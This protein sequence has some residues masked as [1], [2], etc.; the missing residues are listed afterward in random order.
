ME[1]FRVLRTS[2]ALSLE[3]LVSLNSAVQHLLVSASINPANLP[4][5]SIDIVIV[6]LRHSSLTFGEDNLL[7]AQ[8][9][10]DSP[11]I[12]NFGKAWCPSLLPGIKSHRGIGKKLLSALPDESSRFPVVS[13]L[14]LTPINTSGF[15][16]L[17]KLIGRVIPKRLSAMFQA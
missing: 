10:V 16:I 6:R 13:V 2:S 8:N 9:R 11:L 5:L 7:F 12:G 3:P 15:A 4:P 14:L 1:S 17:E